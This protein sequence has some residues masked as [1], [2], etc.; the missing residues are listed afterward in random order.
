MEIDG[1]RMKE[2]YR[3]MVTIRRFEETV[4][5]FYTRAMM[6]G[7]AHLYIGEEAVAVGACAAIRPD[8]LITSTH[9]GHGHC[10]AKGGDLGRMMAEILGKKTGYCQGKGG[11]THI[12]DLDL[13]ILGAFG[14]VGAG[15]APAT[16]AAL[17]AKM[18][19]TDRVVLCF[20]GDGAANQGS[21][22]ESLN[23]AGLWK[24]PVVYVCENNLYGMTVAQSRAMPISDIA[25][26][27][28]SYAMPGVVVDG[29][30]VMA[31]YEAV[32]EAV[33]R[34]RRGEGSTLI[35][36]KTYR[37]GGHHVGDPGTAYRTQDEIEYWKRKRDPT[38]L[39]RR[40]L[41]DQGV[42]SEEEAR[43][44]EGEVEKVIEK[45]I[46]FAKES[47][48]P[49]LEEVSEHVFADKVGREK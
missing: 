2:M 23:L 25:E 21:F 41:L 7:L 13:G 49:A 5:D 20:F 28:S 26:R 40:N 4:W 37:F 30:D 47:P 43:V 32:R 34:A 46:E 48:F 45:A 39:F 11:S 38:A 35:E 6:P 36:C 17:S 9:R 22:H 44:I 19:R 12:A 10:I 3:Q 42:M 27:A 14:I 15:I 18:R 33:E 31:V 8:D 29:Q 1:A 16:G 24:L